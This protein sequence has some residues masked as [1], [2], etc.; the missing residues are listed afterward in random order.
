MNLL[1]EKLGLKRPVQDQATGV[2]VVFMSI[3][4]H[5]SNLLPWKEAGCKI[6]L[7]G[8][9]EC[10][11]FDYDDLKARLRSYL[12]TVCMKIGSFSAGSNITGNIFDTDRIAIMCH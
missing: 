1:V 10:G 6:E 9:T 7:I 8:M 11:D 3:F 12:G 4:E 2:P 5:N